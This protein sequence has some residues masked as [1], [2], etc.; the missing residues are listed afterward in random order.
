METAA[1]GEIVMNVYTIVGIILSSVF[2]GGVFGVGI[3]AVIARNIL[4]NEAGI[5][6]VEGLA[7]SVPAEIAAKIIEV[8]RAAEPILELVEEAFDGIPAASKTTDS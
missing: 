3:F 1:N 4:N 2:A 5:K 8:K 6:A 7:G